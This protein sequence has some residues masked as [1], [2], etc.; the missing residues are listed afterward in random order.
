MEISQR[1]RSLWNPHRRQ[2]MWKRTK[3]N[4][5]SFDEVGGSKDCSSISKTE[6]GHLMEANGNCLL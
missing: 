6:F 4:V 1:R 2:N 5:K 3:K